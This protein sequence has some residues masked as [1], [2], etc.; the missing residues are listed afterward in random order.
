M[1]DRPSLGLSLDPA[2]GEP[3]YRQLFDRIVDRIRSG[4]F[5]PG[6]RL[7]PSRALAD[8]LGAH[9]NTVVRAYADL[10][11]AGFVT[12]TVGRGTFV[13]EPPPARPAEAAPGEGG[14]AWSSLLSRTASSEPLV[15]YTRLA[16]A[17]AS[18]D[19]IN[20]TRMQPPPELLPDDLLRRCTEHVLKK[21]GPR[22]L[23]YAPR[24]GLPALREQ[25]AL[26]LARQGVPAAADDV[27][28]T[29]GSQQALGLLATALVNPGDTVLVENLTYAGAIQIF[30][31]AG[32]RLVPVPADEQG[33][34]IEA[35]R[36]LARTGPRL[37][38]LMP[39]HN[40]PTGAC[41]SAAR[42]AA[43]VEWSHESGVPLVEDDYASDLELDGRLPPAALR[44]LDGQVLFVGTYSKKLA[45]ALRIGFVVAPAELRGPL[46][47]LKHAMDL[48]SSLLCQHVLAEFLERG[49]LAPHLSRVCEAYRERRTALVS[50]LRRKLP[51]G[52]RLRVAER[53]VSVWLEL[54]AG[55][56]SRVVFEEARRRSVVVSP[57]TLH[58]V[59]EPERHGLK[60]NFCTEP[61][62]RL[63]EGGRR[64]ADAIGAALAELGPARAENAPF[65]AL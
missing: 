13:V 61:P 36:Q 62:R 51:D 10:A 60:L 40:N 44:A 5:P 33:P 17:I 27:L 23:G 42:R 59:D 43:L 50:A 28:V 39:N 64:V 63:A 7:P 41:I 29:T 55:L 65:A 20:L 25:I 22:A 30:V 26:D 35:L 12:S 21:L 58:R 4:A 48:G 16:R 31:A 45:P 3:L 54:P 53:G 1:T 9:R 49:Y 56:D 47:T 6:T 14:L 37:L 38:Y 15:R 19:H 46:V 18:G 57:G 32:A 11:D 2:A 34:D 24:E 8:E 52:V